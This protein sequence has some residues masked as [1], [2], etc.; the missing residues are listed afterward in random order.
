MAPPKGTRPPNAGK[1]RQKGSKNKAT[2]TAAKLRAALA[3]EIPAILSGV[4][5]AAKDGDIQGCRIILDRALPPIK[6]VEAPVSVAGLTGTLPEQGAAILAAMGAGELAPGQ[7]AQLLA[8]LA[9]QAKLIEAQELDRRLTELEK[10]LEGGASGM[11]PSPSWSSA[12][13]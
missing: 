10:R 13:Q 4:V 1:G 8:A 12:R 11:V 6:A 7:A 5:K 9:S 3:E 2:Q